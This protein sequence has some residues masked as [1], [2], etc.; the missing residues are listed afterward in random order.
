[1]IYKV[2]DRKVKVHG[3]WAVRIDITHEEMTVK[4]MFDNKFHEK[5][6]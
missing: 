1:M 2:L 6:D 5:K 3:G 4:Y